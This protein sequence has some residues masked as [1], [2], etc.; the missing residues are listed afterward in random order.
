MKRIMITILGLIFCTQLLAT[1]P[2]P[3]TAE[4]VD[5][6]LAVEKS[7]YRSVQ[8][9]IRRMGGNVRFAYTYCDG[10]AVTVPANRVHLISRNPRIKGVFKDQMLSLP[11]L[12]RLRTPMTEEQPQLVEASVDQVTSLTHEQFMDLLIQMDNYSPLTNSIINAIPFFQ[13]TGHTGEGIIVGIMDSGI[14]EAAVAVADRIV[15][16]ENFTGDGIPATS[17]QNHPHGTWVASCVGANAIFGF[18]NKAIQ[19]AVKRY[20]P[21]CVIPDYFGPGRDGIPMVGAAPGALFYALK[22]FRTNGTTSN[23]IILAAMDRVLE[24]KNRYNN[25]EPGGVNIQVLNLSFGSATLYAGEDP[26]FAELVEQMDDVGIVVVASAGNAG[27]S[28]LTG[29]DP[30]L[31]ENI[32]TV[33]ASDP[34]VYERIVMDIFFLGPGGGLFYRPLDNHLIAEF[35]ARGPTPD[36]RPDPE[37]VAPG[38]WRYVQH[39]NGRTINWV[40]GTSFS[41]PTVAGVAALLLSAQPD[42]SPDAIRGALLQGANPDTIQGNPAA[43]QDQGYGLVDAWNAYLALLDGA[44][45]PPDEGPRKPVVA[46]NIALSLMEPIIVEDQFT[47][48][49]DFLEPGERREF[50]VNIEEDVTQ[51]TVQI[52]RVEREL[53]PSRQNPL[54]GDDLI[55]AIHSAKTSRFG[56]GDYLGGTPAFVSSPAT[57]VVR[58]ADLDRGVMRVTVV[59]DW[60]N[61]GRIRATLHIQKTRDPNRLGEAL[62]TQPIRSGEQLTFTVDVPAGATQMKASLA[63]LRDWSMWPTDDLDLIIESPDGKRYYQGATL[64]APEFVTLYNPTPGTYRL[65]VVG[66]TIWK[67]V[68]GFRLGVTVTTPSATLEGFADAESD[69]DID[70][71]PVTFSLEQNYP[72]PFNPTTRIPFSIAEPTTVL[73][74]IFDV[75]G[76][77]IRTLLDRPLGAGSHSVQWDGTDAL[78]RPLPSGTYIYRLKAGSFEQYRKMLLLK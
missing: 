55:L 53:P 57:F 68:D 22:I 14:S 10:M 30:G 78:G 62:A 1:F 37:V 48:E 46:A 23:S 41:A 52:S 11:P 64:D 69:A 77:L 8:Q 36:G 43:K 70:L 73:L 71:N 75:Q 18:S 54:F 16:G 40:S 47:T 66:Y 31:A 4:T 38:K 29:G 67:R 44:A 39:A 5:L 33:G 26:F 3:K 56:D 65:Y 76:R 51:L 59:G 6:I 60:T 49:L 50:F 17:P 24:L 32:I 7:D 20:C 72:N 34:A 19:R 58:D 28:G 2:R 63:W 74:Q 45:N 12:P 27:P 42:A 61:A 13:N 25:G 15:G 9:W 35:S 21:D